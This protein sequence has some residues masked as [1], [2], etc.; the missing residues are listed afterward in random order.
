MVKHVSIQN[1]KSIKS[2]E[3]EARRV[4]VF[5]GEPNTGKSNILDA[6]GLLAMP[7]MNGRD[8]D[9]K[10]IFRFQSID[11]L[12]YEGDFTNPFHIRADDWFARLTKSDLGNSDSGFGIG[13][14]LL[15][16]QN[17]VHKPAYVDSCTLFDETTNEATH[18]VYL[19]EEPMPPFK[20]YVF[21]NAFQYRDNSNL[22][23]SSPFGENLLMLIR[24]NRKVRQLVSDIYESKGLKMLIKKSTQEIEMTK[25]FEDGV[26]FPYPFR[27]TS[28]TL[29]RISFYYA[30]IET[31]QDATILLEEPEV[32][33]FPPFIK[34]L[35]KTIAVDEANQYFIV[36]HNPYLL[37]ILIQKTPS[38]DL[39]VFN[40]Y[41][42]DYQTK[43]YRLTNDELS[44]VWDYEESAFFN[45]DRYLPD[46]E[47]HR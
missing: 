27:F 20:K 37:D 25:G 3:F 47:V 41:M 9:F 33:T 17:Y 19:N 14:G 28:D 36:T 32:F 10:K 23:L 38:V 24:S 8:L 26:Y 40:T 2:L 45:L 22:F 30:A 21:N 12:L 42:E 4:N 34:Q 6:L 46:D 1:F 13:V 35:A 44:E 7:L 5:I 15:D 39:N 29:Q 31:N 16:W 11:D 18:R 43:L